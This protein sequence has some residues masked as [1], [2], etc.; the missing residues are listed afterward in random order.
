MEDPAEGGD[1]GPAPEEEVAA[2]VLKFRNYA[3][4]DQKHI[5]HEKV[6]GAAR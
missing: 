6:S 2:P 3:V 5:E 1:A 4:R